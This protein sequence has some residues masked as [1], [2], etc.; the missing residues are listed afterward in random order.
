L[1]V[2]FEAYNGKVSRQARLLP[3]L[4]VGTTGISRRKNEKNIVCGYYVIDGIHIVINAQICGNGKRICQHV[5][6]HDYK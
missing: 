4:N 2:C 5:E 1:F 6:G 3:T